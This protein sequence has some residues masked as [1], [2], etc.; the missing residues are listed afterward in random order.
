MRGGNPNGERAAERR[1]K[2]T[3][4]GLLVRRAGVITKSFPI[5][6]VLGP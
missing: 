6:S 3:T 2:Y 5:A 1:M 4:P